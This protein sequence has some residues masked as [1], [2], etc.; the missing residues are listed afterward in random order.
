[1]NALRNFIDFPSVVC[2]KLSDGA[3]PVAGNCVNSIRERFALSA[4]WEPSRGISQNL[5]T[6]SD[7]EMVYPHLTVD[8]DRHT[9]AN[10]V[11]MVRFTAI[12]G[13][14]LQLIFLVILSYIA[15][16][17]RV[18]DYEGYDHEYWYYW[19]LGDTHHQK[20]SDDLMTI[21]PYLQP[22]T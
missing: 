4:M 3:R 14:S 22:G 21:R 20:S 5:H 15:F 6:S 2:G 1:M 13:H 8:A 11:C 9:S 12:C 7:R 10:I 17:I 19:S 18:I 16:D